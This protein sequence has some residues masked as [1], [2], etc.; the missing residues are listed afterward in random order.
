[1]SDLCGRA[2][3][4]IFRT[5]PRGSV[6]AK[7]F[8]DWAPAHTLPVGI[9]R[10][11]RRSQSLI[12]GSVV[13]SALFVS[14]GSTTTGSCASS[15]S[16]IL[17]WQS[18]SRASAIAAWPRSRKATRARLTESA[19][20]S[21]TVAASQITQIG[22][23]SRRAISSSSRT[24]ANPPLSVGELVNRYTTRM[25]N[26]GR[27][28]SPFNVASNAAGSNTAGPRSIG[29]AGV[30]KEGSRGESSSHCAGVKAGNSRPIDWGPTM[31]SPPRA[32]RSR[33]DCWARTPS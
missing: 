31:R 8:A 10:P 13:K 29:L 15:A 3:A 2:A 20:H 24:F 4:T 27:S 1:M 14:P 6:D 18:P 19:A 11:Q 17:T 7:A 28:R 12:R 5:T 16:G 23:V 26:E 21:S 33:I 30:R 32:A 25:L 9:D 22:F